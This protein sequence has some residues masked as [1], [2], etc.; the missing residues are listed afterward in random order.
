MNFQNLNFDHVEDPPRMSKA[1]WTSFS[2]RL[3]RRDRTDSRLLD[4]WPSPTVLRKPRRTEDDSDSTIR[5]RHSYEEQ[6]EETDSPTSHLSLS[7]QPTVIPPQA[8]S[9]SLSRSTPEVDRPNKL[10]GTS[11]TVQPRPPIDAIGIATGQAVRFDES[12]LAMFAADNITRM[13]GFGGMKDELAMAAGKV[14]PGVD[15]TPYIQYALEALTRDP[16]RSSTSQMTIP[17]PPSERFSGSHQ[18]KSKFMVKSFAP[19]SA[20]VSSPP[21]QRYQATSCTPP[22]PPLLDAASPPVRDESFSLQPPATPASLANHKPHAMDHWI[23]V[24]KDTLLTIDP[25]GRTYRP[26][27]FKPRILRPFSMLT[28][29]M[30]CILMMAGLIFS[31]VYSEHHAGLTPYPGSIYSGQYFLFRILPQLLAGVILL[32][33]QNIITA[34]YRTLPFATLAKEDP[35]AR[36]LA[37]FQ[38]LYPSSFLLPQ[39]TGPWQLKIFSV[40]TWLTSF[41]IPLQSTAFTCTYVDES[42]QWVWTTTVGTVWALVAIYAILLSSTAVLMIFWFGHWTGLTWDVRSIA[43]LIPLIQRTNTISSYKRRGLYERNCDYRAELRERWF[44]RL[45]YWQTGAVATGGIWHTIGSTAMP[46]ECGP[47]RL[48]DGKSER[49][50]N[51]LSVGS[52]DI[53][54]PALLEFEGGRYLPWCLRTMQLLVFVITAAALML[55]LLI[56]SFLPQ[57]Q[58]EAGFSPKLQARP[59]PS[60]FSAANFLYSFL[61]ALLGMILFLAFQSFD[62]ALR[63][64]QPWADMGKLEGAVASKSILVDYAACL[65]FQATWRSLRNGHWR[66]AVTSLMSVLFI[67]IPILGG[68]LFMALTDSDDEVRMY[69]SMP[70]YGVLLALLFLYMGCLSLLVPRRRQFCVPHSVT[71]IAS[72]MNFCTARDLFEDAAF[73]SVRSRRD[74]ESRLGVGTDDPREESVWFFGLLAGRDEKRISVRRMRR[75]TEKVAMMRSVSSMV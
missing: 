8:S 56:V 57:T 36:Y 58:L 33:A 72:L 69:P 27:T 3:W 6:I 52:R 51:E 16:R 18:P 38:N 73:R 61:P 24:D 19:A 15:D 39:L 2:H 59:D 9:S 68:G 4:Q 22:E 11:P 71:T 32:Y 29:M 21:Q 66:V 45:G 5:L 31:V 35:Q 13:G 14:T 1:F 74:L 60:A 41:T 42:K 49:R 40:A 64:V 30:T 28:L 34:S 62:Q 10:L 48:S 75:Y 67:F 53:P 44:D 23:P 54:H 37:L 20:S 46:A 17:S 7:P 65:P 63:I 70:V 25:R 50:S 47:D 26:L 43:D 55:A 12:Q